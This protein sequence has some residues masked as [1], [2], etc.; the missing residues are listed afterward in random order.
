[1]YPRP[2][3]GSKVARSLLKPFLKSLPKRCYIA[4]LV[5]NHAT[6][7]FDIAAAIEAGQADVILAALATIP[8]YAAKTVARIESL[9]KDSVSTSISQLALRESSKGLIDTAHG[10]ALDL[11]RKV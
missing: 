2:T 7:I 6:D 5:F 10:F 4:A 3:K 8:E 9:S 11:L 1:M